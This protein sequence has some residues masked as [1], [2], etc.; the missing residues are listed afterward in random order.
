LFGP[1]VWFVIGLFYSLCLTLIAITSTP[2]LVVYGR[3]PEQIFAPLLQAAR[4]LDPAAVADATRLQI[5]LPTLQ[6]QLRVAGHPGADSAQVFAFE[7]NLRPRFWH[8][9]QAHLR[10]SVPPEP[11]P[12]NLAGYAMLL[13]A[14]GLIGL[15]LWHSSGREELVVEGFR[16]W[17]WR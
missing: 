11:V 5:T 7:P 15:L 4:R 8:Q 14:G 16:Q 2:K 12:R 17:L 9:L 3:S 6:V 13:A 10:E 1:W